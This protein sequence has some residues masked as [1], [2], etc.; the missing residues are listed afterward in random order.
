M[1]AEC[2]ACEAT[3]NTTIIGSYEADYEDEPPGKYSLGKCPRCSRP[4]LLAQTDWGRGWVDLYQLYPAQQKINHGLPQSIR[5]TYTEALGCYKSK[6][7]IA[8]AIMCRKTLEGIC[9]EHGIQERNLSTSLRKMK[10]IGVIESRLFEWADALRLEGNDAAH[11]VSAS[12]SPEDAR[13]LLEFT[14]ALL[15]YVFTFRDKFEAFKKRRIKKKKMT[16]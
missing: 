14:N 10:E 9:A 13:D 5:T 16:V 7:Y 15:E 3:V 1:L 6:A 8:T 2:S 12:V 4:I 11:N